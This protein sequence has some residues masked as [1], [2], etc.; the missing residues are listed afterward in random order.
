MRKIVRLI[1]QS[2][3]MYIHK[4]TNSPGLG[5]V[6]KQAFLFIYCYQKDCALIRLTVKYVNAYECKLYRVKDHNNTK[7]KQIIGW[8]RKNGIR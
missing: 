4:Y 7:D 5:F 6:W 8:C 1:S 3:G 2:C